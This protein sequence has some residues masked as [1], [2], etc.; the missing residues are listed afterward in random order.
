MR[1]VLNWLAAASVFA[2]GL[3][4]VGADNLRQQ[5]Q[6]LNQPDPRPTTRPATQPAELKLFAGEKPDEWESYQAMHAY[7]LD[8]FVRSERFGSERMPA[9]VDEARRKRI[10]ADGTRYMVGQVQLISLNGG[11]KPFAYATTSGDVTMDS[12]HHA[13]P[14][15]PDEFVLSALDELKKGKEVVLTGTGDGREFIGA[16]RVTRACTQCHRAPKGH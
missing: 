12:K 15:E 4:A 8:R 6:S 10:Y 14:V 7:I 1:T 9:V 2:A 5:H 13:Q 16:V 3:A 11:K